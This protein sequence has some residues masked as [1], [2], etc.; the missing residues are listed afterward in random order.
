MSELTLERGRISARCTKAQQARIDT[1]ASLTGVTINQFVLQAALEKADW[2]IERGR[3]I[4]LS[5]ADAA[6]ILEMLE[7]PGK[8]NAE[9][10]MAF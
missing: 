8:P 5:V 10:T 4:A 7:N 1:A 3:R 9:L 6:M 2:V